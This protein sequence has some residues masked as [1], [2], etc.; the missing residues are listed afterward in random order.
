M[1]SQPAI[2]E[3]PVD[4]SAQMVWDVLA[5][6]WTYA[7]WVVGASRVR[8]VEPNW[9]EVGSL[10]HH[11]FGLW[12]LVINDR[13]EVLVSRP[14]AQL[15]LQAR[16]WLTGEARVNIMITDL[17]PQKSLVRIQEDVSKGPV[18]MA[19]QALRQLATVPRNRETLRRL[20]L[21]AQGR[22]S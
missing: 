3:H 16:G 6:G 4:A 11:S 18:L 7:S 19:P 1:S 21:L 8:G 5:D 15:V 17:G 20:G 9:P 14:G 2:V 22:M 10:L 12:P 13:T